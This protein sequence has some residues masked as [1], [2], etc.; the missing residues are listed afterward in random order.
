MAVNR[1]D[2]NYFLIDENN[3]EPQGPFTWDELMNTIHGID[4]QDAL[5]EEST[6]IIDCSSKTVKQVKIERVIKLV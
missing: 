2:K 1:K 6:F 4:S 3:A 5:V